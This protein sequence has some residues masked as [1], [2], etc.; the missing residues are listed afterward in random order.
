MKVQMLLNKIIQKNIWK[1]PFKFY[2]IK[3]TES[4]H[5]ENVE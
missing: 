2:K 5:Y 1:C 4:Y 3:S